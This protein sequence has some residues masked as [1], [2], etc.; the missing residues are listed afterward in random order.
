MKVRDPAGDPPSAMRRA[1]ETA[2]AV[3]AAVAG[4]V[5]PWL[6]AVGMSASSLV[7]VAN[8]LRAGRA[9]RDRWSGSGGASDPPDG[10]A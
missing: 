1:S 3:P 6:A 10:C 8:S 2:L 7:V 4:L 5:P 9:P